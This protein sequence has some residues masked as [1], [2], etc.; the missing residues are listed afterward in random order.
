MTDSTPIGPIAPFFI[1]RD[2]EHAIS[3]YRDQLGFEARFQAPASDPFF[4]IVGRD[5]VEI[6][7]K[8]IDA[9]VEPQPNPSR[10]EWAA[11]DA[12]VFVGDPDALAAELEANGVAIRRALEDRDDGL[13]GF[14]IRD[15]DGYVL[16][17]G[18]P[19]S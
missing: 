14:E 9:S 13:R 18:R 1:V 17:F 8:V 7:L 12:F 16:F 5:A 3:F 2:L 11:W 6:H 15:R 19:R 10:H 4:A